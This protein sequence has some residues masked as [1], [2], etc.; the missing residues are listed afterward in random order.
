[1][2]SAVAG[3]SGAG[4]GA[5][6]A[7]W[8]NEGANESD[9]DCTD[10]WLSERVMRGYAPMRGFD[11]EPLGAADRLVEEQPGWDAMMAGEWIDFGGQQSTR[12]VQ[13]AVRPPELGD[14]VG[15]GGES[16]GSSADD[17]RRD[18]AMCVLD[19][20]DLRA[21]IS[22][23]LADKVSPATQAAVEA[24]TPGRKRCTP[25]KPQDLDELD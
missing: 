11:A 17:G 2:L 24:Y 6:A 15:S 20:S 10:D 21:R 1:M 9:E 4:S 7:P 3:G 19:L 16:D 5:V 23:D 12:R 18:E 14:E 22:R 25:G 8:D 13:L